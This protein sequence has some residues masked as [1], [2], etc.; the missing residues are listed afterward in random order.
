MFVMHTKILI[1][2]KQYQ[3]VSQISNLTME[4]IN[5]NTWLKEWIWIKSLVIKYWLFIA[6]H[7]F[8][9]WNFQLQNSSTNK[10]VK[11]QNMYSPHNLHGV[12]MYWSFI[13]RKYETVWW[14]TQ[15]DICIVINSNNTFLEYIKRY[16]SNLLRAETT[17]HSTV[18]YLI[19]QLLLEI[20]IMAY[21]LNFLK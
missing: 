7:K 14:K 5:I 17:Q 20:S 15:L 3:Q 8:S 12:V 21:I 1:N 19:S 13:L 4:K 16:C 9:S 18:M 10:V 11:V 6:D 2:L